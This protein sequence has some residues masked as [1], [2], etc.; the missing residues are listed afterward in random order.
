M[1]AFDNQFDGGLEIEG[2]FGKLDMWNMDM[3]KL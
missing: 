2:N 3:I 1:T